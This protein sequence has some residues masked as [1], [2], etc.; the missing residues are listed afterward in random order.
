MRCP[1]CGGK[2]F[3]GKCISCSRPVYAVAFELSAN[4]AFMEALAAR[5]GLMMFEELE[6]LVRTVREN[7][8]LPDLDVVAP[9]HGHKEDR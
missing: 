2:V 3:D 4:H 5:E 7:Y 1:I 9:R 8:R 6:A